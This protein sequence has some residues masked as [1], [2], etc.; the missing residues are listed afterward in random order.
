MALLAA[1]LPG[2]VLAGGPGAN[3]E[4]MSLA[5]PAS[6][7]ASTATNDAPWLRPIAR[8]TPISSVSAL[9]AEYKRIRDERRAQLEPEYERRLHADGETAAEEW[10]ETTLRDVVR[11]DRRDLRARVSR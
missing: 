7:L 10:R 8:D 1:M 3:I 11:R 9:R 2:V 5:P 6:A 4:P